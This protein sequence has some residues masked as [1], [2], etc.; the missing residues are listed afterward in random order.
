MPGQTPVLE[1]KF[2]CHGMRIA[3]SSEVRG[4]LFLHPTNSAVSAFFSAMMFIYTVE[5]NEQNCKGKLIICISE[6]NIQ[7]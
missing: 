6:K 4:Q 5:C 1:W 3:L 7:Y 2:R